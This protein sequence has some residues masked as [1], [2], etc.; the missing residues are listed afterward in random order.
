MG[1]F[2]IIAVLAIVAVQ[3]ARNR[4]EYRALG[5]ANPVGANVVVVFKPDT[6]ER[7]LRRVLVDSGSRLVG[8]PTTTGAY[9]LAVSADQRN[10]VLGR[11]RNESSVVLAESLEVESQP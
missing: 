6:P 8:G 5:S 9:L 7:M 11:L 3:P 2:A 10:L 1:Q 4:D